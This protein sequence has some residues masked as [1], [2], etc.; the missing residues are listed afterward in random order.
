MAITANTHQD[1]N[2]DITTTKNKIDVVEASRKFH[3]VNDV[4]ITTTDQVDVEEVFKYLRVRLNYFREKSQFILV[5]GVH[6][7]ESGEIGA[8]DDDLLYDFREMFERFHNHQKWP[9]EAKIVQ[10]KQFLIGTVIPV[11]SIRD[12]HHK[13]KFLI[14]ESSRISF[15][16]E[17]EKIK[18][19]ENPVVL[20]VASCWS[21][22]SQLSNLLL[23]AGIFSVLNISEERAKLTL[24]RMLQL[25]E[26][27]QKFL[28]TIT[29]IIVIKDAIVGGKLYLF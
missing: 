18:K 4:I 17:F 16:I 2:E 19:T 3:S 25:D 15:K 11:L 27:Q 23:S 8:I 20:I 13:G 12:K 6:T 7:S 14:A 29:Q 28:Q 24:G 1:E 22:R 21:Y 26:K 5:G 10:E 9:A